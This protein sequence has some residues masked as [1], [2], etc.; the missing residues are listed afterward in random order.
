MEA[1]KSWD[2]IGLDLKALDLAQKY[3]YHPFGG[4]S[5]EDVK[6]RF[7]ACIDEI[8]QNEKGEKILVVVHGGI[9]RLLHNLLN[10]EVHEK[11]HNSS[12]HEFD[13]ED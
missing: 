6:K 5:M 11:I 8:R 7:F 13:F 12:V 4:E 9:I 10:N 2:E 3:D 1:G